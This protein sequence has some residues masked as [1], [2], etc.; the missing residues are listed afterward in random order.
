MPPLQP[1]Q[2]FRSKR[3][4]KLT[5]A[6]P[7]PFKKADFS[8]FGNN[9][10]D[11]FLHSIFL[12]LNDNLIIRFFEQGVEASTYDPVHKFWATEGELVWSRESLLTIGEM[13]SSNMIMTRC[14]AERSAP[15]CLSR[16]YDG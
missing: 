2:N 12:R 9:K 8:D 7:V 16:T 13:R 1:L 11:L 3:M 6:L 15:T 5:E 4:E 10:N 14:G